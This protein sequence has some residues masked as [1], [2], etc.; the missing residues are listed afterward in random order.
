V[1][2]VF[3]DA[4]YWI[5]LLNPKDELHEVAKAWTESLGPVGIVTTEMVLTEFLNSF[6]R[7][8]SRLRKAALD[9]IDRLEANPN[10]SIVPQT[11]A[12]FRDAKSLYAERSDKSWGLTDCASIQVM[13]QQEIHEAL[14]HD[15]HFEQ[16]GLVALLRAPP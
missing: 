6:A 7:M 3:A 12:Q 9:L 1:R 16:A 10:V 13:K 15:R 11:G 8:G 5:A 4:N 14:S 2:T